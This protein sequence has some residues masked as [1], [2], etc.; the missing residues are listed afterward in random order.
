MM[1]SIYEYVGMCVSVCMY[2]C[3]LTFRLSLCIMS[4]CESLYLFP[5]AAGES[6]RVDFNNKIKMI[7]EPLNK[8]L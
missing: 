3:M 5:S 2:M 4:G 7:Y 1:L 8:E 6:L